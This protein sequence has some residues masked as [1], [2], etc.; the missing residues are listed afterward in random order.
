MLLS[1]TFNPLY[2]AWQGFKPPVYFEARF[3]YLVCFLMIFIAYQG[4]CKL[5][6]VSSK[7]LHLVFGV[8]GICFIAFQRQDYS[9]V[10]DQNVLYTLAFIAIY[11]TIALLFYK[12]HYDKKKLA[13]LLALIVT[14]EL[15]TNASLTFEKINESIEND[16]DKYSTPRNLASGSVRQLDSKVCASRGVSFFPFNIL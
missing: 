1:L 2:V 15:T 16:E 3:S 9:F 6:A 7:R 4:Y 5:Q 8:I 10:G 11:F 14:L 12:V 13:I